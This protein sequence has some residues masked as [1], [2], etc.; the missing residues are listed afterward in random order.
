LIRRA[1]LD[2]IG[3]IESIRGNMIDDC[4][5]AAAVKRGGGREWLGLTAETRSIRS[6]ATVSE[7]GRMISR[8]AFSQLRH[9]PVLLLGTTL[10][11]LLTFVLPPLLASF[12]HQP[13]AAF[14][15]CAWLLMSIAYLPALRFYRAGWFWAPLL[16]VI[17]SSYLACTFH[18]AI[19]YYRGTGGRW[20]GRVQDGNDKRPRVPQSTRT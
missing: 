5:L 16:P 4:A 6:Y 8:S 9:A 12:A 15:G 19:A 7:I 11:L 3:G 2:R 14:A 17:A 20:K 13:A 10:G 1:T 18:S